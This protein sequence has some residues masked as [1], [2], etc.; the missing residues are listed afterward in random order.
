MIS[1]EAGEGKQSKAVRRRS[2]SEARGGQRLQNH[3]QKWNGEGRERGL[4]SSFLVGGDECTCLFLH[5]LLV[6]ISQLV[7]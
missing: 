3:V 2:G 4:D 6:L 1:A 5:L 7:F